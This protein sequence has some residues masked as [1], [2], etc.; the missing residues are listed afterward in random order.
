MERTELST[1]YLANCV[2][3]FLEALA[4]AEALA[5]DSDTGE[6]LTNALYYANDLL[7]IISDDIEGLESELALDDMRDQLNAVRQLRA[8]APM[9]HQVDVMVTCTLV[10]SRSRAGEA[11]S[12]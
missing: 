9:L 7:D 4:E 6:R 2:Q 3:Y 11:L 12:R 8:R 1:R 10:Q 5:L